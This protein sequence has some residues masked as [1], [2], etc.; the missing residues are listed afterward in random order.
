MKKLGIALLVA[1]GLATAAIAQPGPGPGPPPS[2]WIQSG[3]TVYYNGCV[4][5]PLSV[6]G[7]C[8]GNGT[9]NATTLYQAGRAVL[10]TDLANGKIFVGN[11]SGVATARTPAG[12]VSMTNVGVFSVNSFNGGT[13]FGS[14][15]GI[16]IGTSGGT[17]P[18]NN[19]A[20]VFSAAQT[21]ST[22]SGALPS[23]ITGATLVVAG[24]NGV[25][26]RI[27]ID[28]FGA[29]SAFTGASYGG[30]A[31]AP[32]QVLSGTQLT[33]VNAYAYTGSALVGPIVSFR[34][35]A[36]ENIGATAWGTKACIATTPSTT[37]VLADSLCQQ[38]SGGITVGAPT[39]GDK[40]AGTINAAG[41]IY[42][43]G[44]AVTSAGI[45]SLTG[46][47]TATGP[48]AAVFTL[49]TAQPDVHTWALAQTFTVAPVFTDA[50]G[51]RTALG[52]GT[53]ATQNA[54][55]IAVTGGTF[56]G[57]TGAGFRDASAAFD[58]TLAFN[59]LSTLTAGRTLTVS[60]GNVAHTLA[61]GTTANTITFPNLASFTVITN[62][63][64]GTVTNTMLANS[65]VTINGTS[66][67]LGAS[68]T[69]TA[70]A[71]T[72]TG[73]TLNATVV[74]TSITTVG[75][76]AG[77]S[78]TTGFTINA[79]LVTVSGT[80]PGTAVA[81]A[82]NASGAPSS[83]FGVVKCDGT[84]ITCASGVITSV[85]GVATSV[86]PGVT[87]VT[88]GTAGGVLAN[89]AG[90]LQNVVLTNFIGGLTLSND[91]GTPNS[92]LDI[93]AG[94]AMDSTNAQLITIGT[95]TKS[96]A[97]AWTSGTGNNGMG[98]GLTIANATWY[99]VML[100]YNGGTPDIWFDTSA[101]G[102]N[103]PAGISGS[104]YRRIGSF[105]TNGSAQILTFSQ[106]NNDFIW[107]AVVLEA[108]INNTTAP[109]IATLVTLGGVPTGVKVVAK[110]RFAL[111]P[112]AASTSATVLFQSPDETSAVAGGT[113]GNA[114]AF[115]NAVSGVNFQGNLMA[116]TDTSARLRWSGTSSN[117]TL[118]NAYADT[119][120]WTDWRGQN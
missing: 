70:A 87:T 42:I 109:A 27:Q 66:V 92:I 61:L 72:L 85:G 19:T 94:T 38:N 71:G 114:D 95:F 18:L 96:T 118:P 89:S 2:P 77:G 73:T 35:Y 75:A 106:I 45:T 26:G 17:I 88:S 100:A 22:N 111:I 97:G 56:A 91:G 102:V 10:S 33:G 98:N 3:S 115:A 6:T 108:N 7:G 119:Y 59:S 67:A 39:G 54:S 104:L 101:T 76:L 68:G 69:I 105:K 117:A 36:A 62:G 25:V 44:T 21:I 52:L 47:G 103:K 43:N 29:I 15:A 83:T 60:V 99:H 12:D 74:T 93:A 24:A 110:F 82:A 120:G 11:G 112:G 41:T 81:T 64:T 9:I 20:N 113:A 48:G 16:N 55:A 32:T 65:S 46:Q 58:V 90:T 116:R 23:A 13:S 37:A 49:S 80:F 50:S 53:M 30:T 1:L 4:T 5:V 51:T 31:A 107:G 78:A 28:S 79:A 57:I 84:T 14:A 40:G 86:Q 34:T 8:K 63:D